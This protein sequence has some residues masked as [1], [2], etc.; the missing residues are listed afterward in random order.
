M[1]NKNKIVVVGSGPGGAIT[2]WKLLKAGFEVVLVER[3]DNYINESINSYSSTEMKYKYNN[4][5]LTLTFGKTNINYVEGNCLGGG[6]EVNSG[7]YHRLPNNIYEKWKA[8]GFIDYDYQDLLNSYQEI[9]KDL[10]IS[11][12]PDGFIP[13]ASTLFSIGCDKSKIECKEIPRWVRYENDQVIRQS[14][15]KTYLRK[16]IDNGGFVLKNS[17]VIKF[18]SINDK[19]ELLVKC[20][21]EKLKI[22]CNDIFI[23]AGAIHSPLI[24]KRSG[25]VNNIGKNLKLHPTFKFIAMFD[26]EINDGNS[27]VPV[28][29]AKIENNTIT[30]GC[31]VSDKNYLSIGLSDSNNTNQIPEWKKM[32]SYYVMICPEGKGKIFNLPFFKSPFVTFS[33]T[34]KDYQKLFLGIK[35]L[36]NILFNAGAKNLFPS[37][38]ING[39][40]KNINELNKLNKS[41]INLM[42]IHLFSSVPM[43][44]SPTNSATNH[45]GKI[46]G[47][48]NVYVNDASLLHDSPSV[49]P[50]GVILAFANLNINNYIKNYEK[51]RL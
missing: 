16:Y 13:K 18:K 29:Q 5:G 21:E 31:S 30:M 51:N 34:K 11:Y 2:A 42:T 24:L 45:Y 25:F 10:N 43:G 38:S 39:Y 28:H 37:A 4:G 27:G 6:S 19:L 36:A 12:A 41:N 46:W 33:L 17:E 3:G 14:M 9:E 47:A 23:C 35:S 7:L 44:N 8:D 15:T 20:G 26:E 40:F 1:K 48:D 32:A 22:F 49:N 50:Q